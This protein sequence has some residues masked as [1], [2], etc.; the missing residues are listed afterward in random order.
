MVSRHVNTLIT[1]VDLS[2]RE[3]PYRLLQGGYIGQTIGRFVEACADD[4]GSSQ[5]F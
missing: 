1:T 5:S 3:D 2:S 4:L